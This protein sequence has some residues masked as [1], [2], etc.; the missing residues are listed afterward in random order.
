MRDQSHDN[1]RMTNLPCC[2]FWHA[3]DSD[4][5]MRPYITGLVWCVLHGSRC[6]W[7][8]PSGCM[9]YSFCLNVQKYAIKKVVLEAYNDRHRARLVDEVHVMIW[10]CFSINIDNNL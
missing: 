6:F 8:W 1:L 4:R 9:L 5:C 10:F 2:I 7:Q 3:G